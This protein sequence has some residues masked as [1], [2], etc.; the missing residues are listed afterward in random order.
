MSIGVPVKLL[1]EAESHVIT[2]EL[3]NGDLYRGTLHESED[4]LNCHLS[5]EGTNLVHT[6]RF[7]SCVLL[8]FPIVVL[9]NKWC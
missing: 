4:N 3:K 6:D 2:I 1:H 9:L 8:S 7:F 5:N